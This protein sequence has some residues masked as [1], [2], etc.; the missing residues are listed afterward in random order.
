M[1]MGSPITSL[2]I[3]VALTYFVVNA[4]GSCEP[5]NIL[6]NTPSWWSPF[7][8]EGG[9]WIF[10]NYTTDDDRLNCSLVLTQNGTLLP[11][12]WYGSSDGT[13]SYSRFN[14]SVFELSTEVTINDFS[15][16]QGY[17]EWALF[18]RLSNW[19]QSDWESGSGYGV[20]A[21][22]FSGG[23][24]WSRFIDNTGAAIEITGKES[25]TANIGDRHTLSIIVN[26]TDNNLYD[27]SWDGSVVFDN[28]D[29]SS[30]GLQAGSV[31]FW[32]HYSNLTIHH[33]LVQELGPTCTPTST[34]T[35][36][37]T[38]APTLSMSTI[39]IFQFFN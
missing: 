11:R 21:Q 38:L 14:Y 35:N 19:S 20:F 12:I 30:Y 22:T 1:Y 24:L 9:T 33:L 5:V 13:T 10:F 18:F 2:M 34:P 17:G 6:C 8:S 28:L 16:A 4:G 31:G 29:L 15:T 23:N 36:I 7:T 26:T 27:I 32:S 25:I 39:L 3:L 37:P